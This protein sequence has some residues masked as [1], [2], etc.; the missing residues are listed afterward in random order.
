MAN[1]IREQR[2]IDNNKRALIKYAMT[3]DS[4]V[5]NSTLVDVSTLRFALNANSY[6]MSSNTDPRSTYRTTIKR[7]FGT[8]KA[9]AYIK[10]Q[11]Q[12]STNSEI[13]TIGSG[14]FNFDFESMG[15]GATISNTE[16]AGANGDILI[17]IITPSSAD[18]ATIFIDLRKNPSDYDQGQTADPAA[19]NRGNYSL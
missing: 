6:I 3:I 17:S 18:M 9:N 16:T 8:A 5:A 13:V 2:I 7:I 1:L 11:W 10:L 19:F 12:G 14:N 4:A 15:D